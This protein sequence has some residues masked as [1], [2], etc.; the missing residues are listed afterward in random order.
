MLIFC[1]NFQIVS[2]FVIEHQNLRL[3]YFSSYFRQSN[4]SYNGRAISWEDNLVRIVLF[5]IEM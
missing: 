3:R 5:Q 4:D 2:L 1:P